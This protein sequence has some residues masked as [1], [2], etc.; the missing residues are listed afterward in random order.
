[1][2]PHSHGGCL[3]NKIVMFVF[4]GAALLL[5]AQ[6]ASAQMQITYTSDPNLGDFTAKVSSYATL[7]NFSAYTCA[8]DNTCPTTPSF[9]PTATELAIYG[10]RVYDGTLTGTGLAGGNNWIMASFQQPTSSIIVFP[11][12]DHYGSSYDGY[13]YTIAGSNDGVNWTVL[14]DATGVSPCNGNCVG[15]PAGAAG[16]PFTLSDHSG[17]APTTV[18]NVLT[19]STTGLQPSC[20]DNVTGGLCA[21]GYIATFNF[22]AAYQYY[23][24]GASTVAINSGNADQELSAVGSTGVTIV[25]SPVQ[26]G[27]TENFNFNTTA[28]STD[29]FS[30][31]FPDVQLTNQGATPVVTTFS[32]PP[33]GSSSL[34]ANSPLA[35]ASCIAFVSANGNC[36]PKLVVCTLG[37]NLPSGAICPYDPSGAEDVLLSDSFTPVTPFT[38]TS[39]PNGQNPGVVALNDSQ[40][41]P[42]AAPFASLPCPSNGL[43]SFTGDPAPVH[44]SSNSYYFYVTGILPPS[45]TPAGFVTVGTPPNTTNWINGHNPNVTLTA[46]PPPAPPSPNNGWYP[47][48]IDYIAYVNLPA[49]ATPPDPNL[50]LNLQKP[51]LPGATVEFSQNTATSTLPVVVTSSGINMMGSTTCGG[52][53][54]GNSGNIL[55]ASP[56]YLFQVPVSLGSL[57]DMAT[58]ALYYETEDCTRTAE[59]LY[60]FVAP[61]W[62]TNYKSVVYTVDDDAPAITI[63]VPSTGAI[64]PANATIKS[65]F[66]C[67]DGVGSGVASCNGPSQIGTTP[68]GGILTSQSFTVTSVDNVGNNSSK[69]VDYSVSCLYAANTISP[70][71]F[72]RGQNFTITPSITNCTRSLQPL[73]VSVVLSG[74]MGTS[75]APKSLTLVNGFTVPV[76]AGASVKATFGPFSVPK[77]ACI[78]MYTFTTTS[79]TKGVT[80][81]VYSQS[82]FVN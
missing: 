52:V 62:T 24:F 22:S 12:I 77:N 75:C 33:S 56:A 73:T 16:E 23:A 57:T 15:G 76:P 4:C 47:S 13:Q 60:T 48:P 31:T 51:L 66:S 7:T 19:P 43:K 61:G 2:Y 54:N 55:P 11:S 74:P 29:V 32:V 20:A 44:G 82:L 78:G 36:A 34:W 10:Y 42:F 39:F 8:P 14:F 70:T 30:A 63:T 46:A 18:N 9:V 58:Y 26:P 79:S 27:S 45:S 71:N 41:C 81:F 35:T 68:S 59:R 49:T 21:I 1:M 64:Y 53:L 72:V 28:G 25:G 38:S 37:A 3:L 67:S 65:S 69:T 17:M 50:P 5:C 40:G 80:D 6:M